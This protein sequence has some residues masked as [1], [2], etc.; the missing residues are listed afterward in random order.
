M[1]V[2]LDV[3]PLPRSSAPVRKGTGKGTRKGRSLAGLGCG[4]VLRRG[5]MRAQGEG[6]VGLWADVDEQTKRL[7]IWAPAT[8]LKA[9]DDVAEAG[10]VE[11]GVFPLETLP[12]AL[13]QLLQS[14]DTWE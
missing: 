7:A 4:L 11:S 13:K 9:D 10:E 3:P 6:V 2:K 12:R 1:A 14:E 8:G 5:A